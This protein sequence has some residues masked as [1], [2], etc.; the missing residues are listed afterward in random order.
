MY[1][2]N[3]I[4]II[5]PKIKPKALPI[6]AIT[7]EARPTLAAALSTCT[8]P[9]PPVT[10]RTSCCGGSGA[11]VG[12]DSSGTSVANS[13]ADVL[14]VV[15]DDTCAPVVVVVD[16]PRAAV[17][18]VVVVSARRA[19]CTARGDAGATFSAFARKCTVGIDGHFLHTNGSCAEHDAVLNK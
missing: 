14:V 16:E 19:R 18:V 8:S 10:T 1:Q 11:A 2:G 17:V 5:E 13:G 15:V 4:H 12:S 7:P 6:A 3:R 9:D